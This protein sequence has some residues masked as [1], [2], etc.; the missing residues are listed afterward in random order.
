MYR[1][2]VGLLGQF[3]G[4]GRQFFVKTPSLPHCE[5][6]FFGSRI[7]CALVATFVA[8]INSSDARCVARG[9]LRSSFTF[10][11]GFFRELRGIHT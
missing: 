2:A 9:F 6:N 11:F 3:L 5:Q 7:G 10:R 4:D 1:G 8:T